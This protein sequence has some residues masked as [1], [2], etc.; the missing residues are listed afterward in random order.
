MLCTELRQES[1]QIFEF[2]VDLLGKPEPIFGREEPI[3]KIAGNESMPAVQFLVIQR[4]EGFRRYPPRQQAG[5]G[6]EAEG[7]FGL[8]DRIEYEL[9]DVGAIPPYPRSAPSRRR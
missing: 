7:G 8:A 1:S 4:Q 9:A 5:L 3:V 2:R 6:N